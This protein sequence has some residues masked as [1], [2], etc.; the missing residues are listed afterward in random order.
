M[1]PAP[2]Q[3]GAPDTADVRLAASLKSELVSLRE[4][5]VILQ[6]EQDALTLGDAERLN[7][8]LADKTRLATRL[9]ACA[10]E[11]TRLLASLALSAD[12]DGMKQWLSR[13][14]SDAPNLG[15]TW[16]EILT[17]ATRAQELNANNGILIA[18]RLQHNQQA[19]NALLAASNQAA[20][21]GPDGQT[22]TGGK[23]RSLGSA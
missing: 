18:S 21:Y 20:L 9:A 15:K 17:Q 10:N 13:P 8:L 3:T 14:Q 7:L 19:L 4:F 11:R 22:H 16:E 5:V 6:N 12:R 23:G 1:S 2:T